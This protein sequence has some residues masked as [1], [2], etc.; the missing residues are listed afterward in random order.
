M[1]SITVQYTG[2]LA[3]LVGTSEENIDIEEGIDLLELVQQLSSRHG[4]ACSDFLLAKEDELQPSLLVIFD[5][6]QI[7]GDLETASLAEVQT[8][9]FMTPIAGG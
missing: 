9:M 7:A 5:G 2:Q 4:E 8:V 3:N 6:E 1:K